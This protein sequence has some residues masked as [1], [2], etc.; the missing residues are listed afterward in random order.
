MNAT[1][2]IRTRRHALPSLATPRRQTADELSR[3][4]LPGLDGMIEL[5]RRL[6]ENHGNRLS[7]RQVDYAQ[8]LYSSAAELQ[9]ALARLLPPQRAAA[10]PVTTG[11]AGRSLLL[12]AGDMRGIYS[13]TGSLEGHG[14]RVLH[15]T[16]EDELDVV[17]AREA[18]ID[19]ILLDPHDSR[20]DFARLSRRLRAAETGRHRPIIAL[21][22]ASL[23]APP[24]DPS[25]AGRR[26]TPPRAIAAPANV[27]RLLT[28][29]QRHLLGQRLG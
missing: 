5:S 26:G 8:T 15:A 21:T 16:D 10:E 24:E 4:L 19:A 20:L 18:R 14:L 12:I 22:D 29:L 13:L 25:P 2:E 28:L 11:L 9:L 27:E 7:P 1:A 6:A 17:L 23:E 3:Q